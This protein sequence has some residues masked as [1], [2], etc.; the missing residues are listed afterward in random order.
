M[1]IKDIIDVQW[2]A[3]YSKKLPPWWEDRRLDL[4]AWLGVSRRGIEPANRPSTGVH[5]DT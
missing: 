2:P 5:H 3:L 1:N 4:I